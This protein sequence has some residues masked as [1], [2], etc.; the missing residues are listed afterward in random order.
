MEGSSTPSQLRPPEEQPRTHSKRVYALQAPSFSYIVF[1]FWKSDLDHTR[2]VQQLLHTRLRHAKSWINQTQV[3]HFQLLILSIQ[4]KNSCT[5]HNLSS[6]NELLL[7]PTPTRTRMQLFS[8][9]LIS[10]MSTEMQPKDK[11]DF[12]WLRR[13]LQQH[14]LI[15][16]LLRFQDA[17]R[18]RRCKKLQAQFRVDQQKEWEWWI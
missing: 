8:L 15:H 18:V 7:P 3:H 10:T 16:D 4:S 12:K 14:D 11:S 5:I 9:P 2:L 1:H 6:R 13:R 17:R